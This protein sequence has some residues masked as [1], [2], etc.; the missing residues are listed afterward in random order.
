MVLL[1]LNAAANLR[2]SKTCCGF[3]ARRAISSMPWTKVFTSWRL[4][5]KPP[6]LPGGCG[7]WHASPWKPQ[8]CGAHV[9]GPS[10]A[11]AII[12]TQEQ[13]FVSL[14]HSDDLASL[15][16]FG[17]LFCAFVQPGDAC[18]PVPGAQ[19]RRAL[20]AEN[21]LANLPHA[22]DMV[23]SLAPPP[24]GRGKTLRFDKMPYSCQLTSISVHGFDFVWPGHAM[25]FMFIHPTV[26][27]AAVDPG[28]EGLAWMF[29][30]EVVDRQEA[31]LE[32]A[33]KES[34]LQLILQLSLVPTFEKA[35]KKPADGAA[36]RKKKKAWEIFENMLCQKMSQ[37]QGWCSTFLP[38]MFVTYV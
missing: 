21:L 22:A 16:G 30:P 35:A 11:A 24:H 8:L 32:S 14:M 9:S 27:E 18:V 13:N 5:D 29:S 19:I 17:G 3:E 10:D 6:E 2:A 7:F 15:R 36:Q 25:L 33:V 23:A 28:P 20:E 12:L 4:C 38:E 26:A 37:H 1:N 34:A 31:L